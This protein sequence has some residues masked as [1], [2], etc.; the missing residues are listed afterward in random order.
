MQNKNQKNGAQNNTKGNSE[1]NPE[2]DNCH[3]N[4]CSKKKDK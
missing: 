4:G 3:G 2:K 1:G